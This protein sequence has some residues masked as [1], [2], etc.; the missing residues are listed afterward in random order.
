M[1]WSAFYYF[2]IS[3]LLQVPRQ[4]AVPFSEDVSIGAPA[5]DRCFRATLFQGE[6]RGL[7]LSGVF[8]EMDVE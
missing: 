3:F 4:S 7:V 6:W 8:L 1:R 5:E 2:D